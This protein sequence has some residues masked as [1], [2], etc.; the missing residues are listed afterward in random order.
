M[1]STCRLGHYFP[2]GDGCTIWSAASLAASHVGR[3]N[4]E[5]Y[6]EEVVVDSLGYPW[7]RAE[8]LK[9][10]WIRLDQCRWSERNHDHSEVGGRFRVVWYSGC[11]VWTS[12]SFQE[13]L[14]DIPKRTLLDV[15][16][17][18]RKGPTLLGRIEIPMEGWI[19]LRL[20]DAVS[21]II[22]TLTIIAD[23]DDSVLVCSSMSGE[24]I[25]RLPVD[26]IMDMHLTE[27]STKLA[28]KL[29]TDAQIRLVLPDGV[30]LTSEG[31]NGSMKV[32][33]IMKS[34]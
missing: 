30:L 13:K 20:C 26:T 27:L 31:Q 29:Q 32:N 34:L 9:S 2:V 24:E 17:V 12:T 6:V 4:T 33:D 16:E 22:V 11:S 14:C 8:S 21:M 3:I 19:N 15:C 1:A 18:Y 5:V 28:E 25:I 23:T 10:G 7:G